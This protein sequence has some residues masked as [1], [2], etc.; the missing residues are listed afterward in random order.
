MRLIAIILIFKIAG[1]LFPAL[2]VFSQEPAFHFEH[3]ASREGLSH[4]AVSCIVQDHH[5]YIWIGTHSGLNKY[6]GYNFEVFLNDPKNDSSISGNRINSLFADSQGNLWIGTVLRGLNLYSE[7]TNSFIRFIHD[8]DDPASISANDIRRIFEDSKG[9]IWVCTRGG[10]LNRLI[11]IKEGFKH[12]V[13]DP[14]DPGSLMNDDVFSI[15]EDKQGTLWIGTNGGGIHR[16]VEEEDNFKFYSYSKPNSLNLSPTNFGAIL[17]SDQQGNIWIGTEIEGLFCF[18]VEDETFSHIPYGTTNK[19]LNNKV[20]TDVVLCSDNKL[21][22]TTDGGGINVLNLANRKFT[23]IK[24]NPYDNSSLSNNQVQYIYR[25]PQDNVWIGNYNGGVNIFFRYK[26]KFEHFHNELNNKKSLSNNAVLC[27]EE[28]S[29][30][31]IW[32]GTDG[33]GLNLFNPENKTFKHFTH[34]KNNPNSISGNVV[35]WITEDND[36]LLWIGTYEEGLNVYNRET[37]TFKHFRNHIQDSRSISSNHVWHIMQDSRGDMYIGTLN[38]LNRYVKE[39]EQFIRYNSISNSTNSLSNNSIMYIYE[40]SFDNLWIGTDGGGLNLM[41]RRNGTFIRYMND[42]EDSTSLSNNLVKVIYEDSKGDLWI[43]TMG[44]GLNYLD[45]KKGIFTA[46]TT[47]NNLPSN[48]INGIIEDD[49]GNLWLSTSNGICRFNTETLE[50]RSYSIDDGLQDAEFTYSSF[51]KAG[52]G[53][54]YFGGINGFNR[55]RPGQL[56]DNSHIPPVV[57][58]HLYIFNRKVELGGADRILK[59]SLSTTKEIRLR[60]DQNV[61]GIE[62]AALDYT[63]PDENRYR[64]KMENFD[65]AWTEVD[66]NHRQAT[67]TNLNPGIYIFKVIASNNDYVWNE[68]G[69]SIKIIISPPFWKTWWFRLIGAL[70]II[71][72]LMV[73]YLIR[74]TQIQK[75]NIFLEKEVHER[76]RELNDKNKLLVDQATEL[77]ESNTLLEERQQKI[78]EQSEELSSANEQLLITNEQLS[79]LNTMKDKFFSIIGHDLKNPI[80]VIMGFSEM[81]KVR[82]DT[83]TVEKRD[84]YIDNIFNSAKNTYDL[85]ENLLTWARSQSGRM[86]LQP[87]SID[88]IKLINSN[89]QLILEGIKKKDITVTTD[90]PKEI[91]N[92]FCD[93]NMADTVIR[94]LIGNAVKYTRPGGKISVKVEFNEKANYVKAIFS[95]DGIGIPADKIDDLFSLDRKYSTEGTA[96]ETGTGLGLLLCKEFIEKNNGNIWVKSG[97][98]KGSVFT[99]TL[100]LNKE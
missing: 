79:E 49:N 38:G 82:I 91:K 52:N 7:K 76:T 56:T 70:F 100:P 44:G 8:Q 5:G 30:G 69:T 2:K 65:K 71:S 62:F 1:L 20:I 50:V 93:N 96:G 3:L 10:G 74:V 37:N 67:Y 23:Y 95:D 48:N 4:S 34:N 12:Y 27:F 78:E 13:H 57:L 85:L 25:D 90:Y 39:K 6:D 42:E 53:D 55:F 24:S 92:A 75:R 9:R 28:D 86:A 88:I 31:N 73:I 80:N 11:S 51:L 43:G 54:Y 36:G 40:D 89:I 32:I 26:R 47:R 72:A 16:Y 35:K 41:D 97:P 33:G 14:D 84:I 58:T 81:L 68:E 99:F 59:T 87:E 22:V 94:N 63:S 77:N 83:L 19:H 29:D 21:W 15:I 46:Y 98:D 64:Y 18:N 61:I 45:R 66:A 17:C 60:Y